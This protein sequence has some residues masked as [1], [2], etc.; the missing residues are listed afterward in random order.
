[1]NKLIDALLKSTE[2]SIRYK[3]RV[4]VLLEEPSSKTVMEVRK[5]V[6][7]SEVVK[8]LLANRDKSGKIPPLE[9]PYSKWIG[10]HWVFTHLADIGYPTNDTTLKPIQDQLFENWLNPQWFPH[11]RRING[12]ARTHASQHGNFLWASLKLGLDDDRNH[13]IAK[14]LLSWQWPDGGWN[15]DE[16]PRAMNSSFWESLLPFRA[17]SLYARTFNDKAALEASNRASEIFLKRVLFK[18]R[19]DGSIMNKQFVQLHYPCY[20]RYDIL[21]ALKVMAE[22][23]FINDSRCAGALD[24]LVLQRKLI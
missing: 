10:A 9:D 16:N 13:T 7:N 17:L 6:G 14:Y 5:E 12:W 15:C 22:A 11:V 4:N 2:P 21:H 3:M 19:S 1:M 8:T 24:L 23:G 18:K 20:W